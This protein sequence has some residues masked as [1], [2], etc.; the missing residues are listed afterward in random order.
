M[1]IPVDITL[2][3]KNEL[4]TH[5]TTKI[6]N[7]FNEHGI[8]INIDNNILKVSKYQQIETD[9]LETSLT[10]TY[11]ISKFTGPILIAKNDGNDAVYVEGTY[12]FLKNELLFTEGEFKTTVKRQPKEDKKEPLTDEE[13][14][15]LLNDFLE[16]N[17]RKPKER[18]MHEGFNVGIYYHSV[19]KYNNVYNELKDIIDELNEV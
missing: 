12:K 8:V 1:L 5:L 6:T 19:E 9:A 3:F 11:K 14:T 10:D 13:K 7:L 16:K 18:E 4:T 2:K 17:K 15:A